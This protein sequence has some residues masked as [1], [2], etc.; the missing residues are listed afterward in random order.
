[1][2]FSGHRRL[3]TVT[4]VMPLWFYSF[5]GITEELW[6]VKSHPVAPRKVE[7]ARVQRL[8]NGR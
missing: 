3:S 5:S 2:N 7:Q 8:M 4:T 6:L 1:M